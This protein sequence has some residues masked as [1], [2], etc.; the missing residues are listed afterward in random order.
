MRSTFLAVL[1]LAAC[2]SCGNEWPL[3]VHLEGEYLVG[4]TPPLRPMPVSSG[5]YGAAEL[6]FQDGE[7]TVLVDLRGEPRWVRTSSPM[8][9]SATAFLRSLGADVH[10]SFF[11]D[12]DR[13]IVVADGS[14]MAV[15]SSTERVRM[16]DHNTAML[17]GCY[18][19]GGRS[20]YACSLDM[21]WVSA[22][23]D[24]DGRELS[25]NFAPAWH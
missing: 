1:A 25:G 10:V 7:T 23:F 20:R 22:E 11:E 16:L 21:M 24:A 17:E 14:T 9:S 8:G 12:G 15:Q 6:R 19:S 18:M 5:D 3:S 13:A 4:T 2:T